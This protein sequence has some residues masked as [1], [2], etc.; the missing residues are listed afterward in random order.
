MTADVIARIVPQITVEWFDPALPLTLE[1]A[2]ENED[3][4]QMDVLCAFVQLV[5]VCDEMQR[6][7]KEAMP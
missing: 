6:R 2:G 7:R 4:W 1:W 3:R 5:H